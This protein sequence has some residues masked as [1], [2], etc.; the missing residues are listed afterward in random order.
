[1]EKNIL[2]SRYNIITRKHEEEKLVTLHEA[3]E[4]LNQDFPSFVTVTA[5]NRDTGQPILHN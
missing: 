1:M 3:Y 4:Y 2:V 5:Y